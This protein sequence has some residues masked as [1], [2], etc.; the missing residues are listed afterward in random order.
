MKKIMALTLALL[1]LLSLAACG[2]K[3][4]ASNDDTT[5]NSQQTENLGQQE[6]TQSDNKDNEQSEGP[7]SM[8][9]E[10]FHMVAPGLDLYNR[11]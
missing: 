6:Q 10:N 9:P 7:A 4:P 1:M 2:E 5:P 8:L 3:T 11:K